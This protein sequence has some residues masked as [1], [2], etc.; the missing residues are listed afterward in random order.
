MSP[1]SP[2]GSHMRLR[3]CS[4]PPWLLNQSAKLMSSSARMSCTHTAHGH[5]CLCH[6]GKQRGVL[7]L[8][9][10]MAMI[11]PPRPCVWALLS[12]LP[13]FHSLPP[14]A[15]PHLS[16]IVIHQHQSTMQTINN[17]SLPLP[18]TLGTPSSHNASPCIHPPLPLKPL[19]SPACPPQGR[20]VRVQWGWC[21]VPGC[22]PPCP[23][24]QA[25]GW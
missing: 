17:H 16:Q 15:A 12:P 10:A 18:Y 13:P 11:D 20:T 14:L 8:S 9:S 1:S 3:L 6:V 24:G 2:M 23:L 5:A 22:W 21:P 7:S 19:N 25:G 4:L